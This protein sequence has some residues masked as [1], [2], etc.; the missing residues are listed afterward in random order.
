M[1]I[2]I[3]DLY[4]SFD[5]FLRKYTKHIFIYGVMILYLNIKFHL[6]IKI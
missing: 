1:I 6:R 5:Y 3:N 4:G 2:S